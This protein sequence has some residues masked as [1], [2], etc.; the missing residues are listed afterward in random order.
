[1]RLDKFVHTIQKVSRSDA[2]KLIKSGVVFVNGVVVK[3]ASVHV[4]ETDT[5]EMN[6]ETLC[7]QEATEELY[8]ILHKPA[9]FVCANDDSNYPPVTKLITHPRARELHSA[10]RLDADTTG[11]VLL[12]TDGQW[13]HRVASPNKQCGKTYQVTLDRELTPEMI[14]QLENG[15]VLHGENKATKPATIE[16]I[17]EKMVL[18]TIHEGKYHQVKRMFAAVGNHVIR[19][20]RQQVGPITLDVTL[21]EGCFRALTKDEIAL[22]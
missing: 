20:H 6:G 9:G 7:L 19:L 4:K 3:S 13:S 15:L 12:T 10:G 2:T 17:H 14:F 22:F 1:M 18:L 5:I 8:F 16:C 21:A 11:L